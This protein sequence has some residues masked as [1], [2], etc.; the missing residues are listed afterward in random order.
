MSAGR[1]FVRRELP[2][3]RSGPLYKIHNNAHSELDVFLHRF[4]YWRVDLD[5]RAMTSREAAHRELARA[6]SFP[7]YYGANWDAFDDCLEDF[8]EQHSGR[9]FAV[10]WDAVDVA[11]CA[12]PA[13]SI[14]VGSALLS[15]STGLPRSLDEH[16]R[17]RIAMDVF[18]LGASDDFD[19]P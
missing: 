7:D 6:F 17:P 5:G 14:E 9:L 15:A 19:R 13:T 8:A 1:P 12:A 10:V 4:S 18:G 2:W 11:A 3:L 16:G